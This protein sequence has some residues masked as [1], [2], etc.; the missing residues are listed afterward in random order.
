MAFATNGRSRV[1]CARSNVVN[2]GFT[3]DT[4]IGNAWGV[5]FT[6][7][8]I[9]HNG[10]QRVLRQEKTAIKSREVLNLSLT[11][12]QNDGPLEI[13]LICS[14][15]LNEK[16]VTSIGN[17]SLAK[18]GDLTGQVARPRLVTLQLTYRFG[19]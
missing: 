7:D 15:C 19:T 8:M 1:G 5:A 10:G 11:A 3:Y 6:G 9:F 18:T 13:S 14:N 17:K 4:P 16:Y 12:Y 2:I